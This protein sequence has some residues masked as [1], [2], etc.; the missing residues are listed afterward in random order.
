MSHLKLE[1]VWLDGYAPLPHIRS[2]T[3][4]RDAEVFDVSLESLPEISVNDPFRNY[5]RV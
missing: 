2:K 4:I 1:Y 5:K 3:L